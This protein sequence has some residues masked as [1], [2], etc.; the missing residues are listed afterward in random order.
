VV[1][2]VSEANTTGQFVYETYDLQLVTGK[3]YYRLKMVVTKARYKYIEV[4]V[5]LIEDK[6][7]FW[8]IQS[9]KVPVW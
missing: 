9:Q 4:K 6:G 7:T 1:G 8:S 5:V 2:R 3:N